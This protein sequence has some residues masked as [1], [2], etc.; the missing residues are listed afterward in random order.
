MTQSAIHPALAT[1]QLLYL[2]YGD[3]AVYRHEAKFSILSALRHRKVSADFTITLMTDQ[4]EAF[5]GWPITVLPLD[6]M[7]LDAWQ[8]A[9]GYYHRRKACAIQAGV[10][11][12]GK[13]IFTDTDTVFFKDP[14]QLF[15]RVTDDQFLMDEFEWYWDEASRRS[16]FSALVTHLKAENKVPVPALRLF[17]SGICGMTKA[18]GDLLEGAISLIDQW[19]HHGATLLT[20][21]QIAM[22]FMLAGRKVVEA[23][24]CINHY[25]SVKRYHHAMYQ[26]FFEEQGERYRDDLPRAT[27]AVPDRLPNNSL[28][29]RLQLRWRFRGQCSTSRKVAKFY[30]LGKQA[31]RS[32]YL[33]TC[34][35]LWWA[36]A[37]DEL[38]SLEPAGK[39]FTKLAALWQADS[40]FLSFIKGNKTQKDER[41]IFTGRV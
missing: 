41:Y 32:S 29:N 39:S 13:T 23:N 11:L 34:K 7:T 22:S 5:D 26:A 40:E 24:D 2:L 1:N 20:I 10:A 33:D 37:V 6:A 25:F 17:N 27:F 16:E 9:G 35:Y 18:N 31:D 12:A 3:K 30:L 28:R 36:V 19:T 4:P 15:K 14:A 8:G 38:S 21:E